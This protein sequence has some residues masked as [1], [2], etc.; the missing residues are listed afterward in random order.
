MRQQKGS[1]A[2]FKQPAAKPFFLLSPFSGTTF[3]H[4]FGQRFLFGGRSSLFAK[5]FGQ[6]CLFARKSSQFAGMSDQRC[7]SA[8]K[9]ISA[10]RN[11]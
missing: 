7:F 8:E 5:M 1:A 10:Q 3:R 4:H 9:S 2:G 11:T 6:G